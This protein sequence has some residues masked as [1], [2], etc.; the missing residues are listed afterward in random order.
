MRRP[1]RLNRELLRKAWPNLRAGCPD[2]RG[3][4]KADI[5]A[6]EATDIIAEIKIGGVFKTTRS[7]R[8]P[9]T[10]QL[11]ADSG[12][13]PQPVILDVG[14]SDGSSSLST[15][16]SIR[17]DRYYVTDRHIEAYACATKTGAFFCDFENNP[18][19]YANRF[20]V[21]YNDGE[22]ALWPMSGI[23]RRLFSS[24]DKSGR[25]GARRMLLMNPALLPRTGSDIRLEKYDIFEAWPFEKVDLVIAANILNRSYFSDAQLTSAVRNLRGALKEAGRLAVIENRPAE[26]SNIFRL[27]DG[28]FVV[29][30]EVGPG[31]DIKL[32]VTDLC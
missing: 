31:S 22:K 4:L 12:L 25:A 21:V 20:V 23:V 13:P 26:Q 16:A 3:L 28:Q 9:R 8:F 10:T 6:Q 19:M 30:H 1:I 29:E 24:F 15:M 18:F 32:L 27:R 5:S 7:N 2:P 14:A 11:L 17:F